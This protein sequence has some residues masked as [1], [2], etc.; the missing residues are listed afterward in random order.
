MPIASSPSNYDWTLSF[1][2]PAIPSNLLISHHFTVTIVILY[3]NFWLFLLRRHRGSWEAAWSMGDSLGAD[4]RMNGR[5]V[6]TA[7]FVENSIDLAMRRG[8]N[9]C[10][11][12]NAFIMRSL[13]IVA[14]PVIHFF[15][16]TCDE[17]FFF[18]HRSTAGHLFHSV[19]DGLFVWRP[20]YT[21]FF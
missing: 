4:C 20:L 12:K 9:S 13:N 14:T 1:R 5:S 6:E 16:V 10:K 19:F 15:A 2:I 17:R 11:F 18:L 21:A 7:E 3:V 8:K